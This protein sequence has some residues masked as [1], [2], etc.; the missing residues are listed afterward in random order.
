MLGEQPVLVMAV[1][2]ADGT[3]PEQLAGLGVELDQ[4]A[5]LA[6]IDHHRAP[7]RRGQHR[8]V[9]QVPVVQVVRGQLVVPQQLAVRAELDHRVGV[10]VR[11]RPAAPERVVPGAEERG[12]VGHADVHVALGVERGRVPLATAGVDRRVP[13]QVL[14][15][16][17][18]P[19]R[20]AGRGVQRPQGG[21]AA[22]EVLAHQRVDRHGGHVD[23]AVVVPGGH[24]DALVVVAD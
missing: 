22:A 9:L 24:V 20:R 21:L 8:R 1:A 11:T 7:V 3:L 16:V 23:G 19:L 13:P 4:D 18:A 6:A 17:P 15:L 2:H 5:G 10:Q 12:G 14:H